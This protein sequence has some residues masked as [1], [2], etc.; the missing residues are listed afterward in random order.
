MA[1]TT[2]ALDIEALGNPTF[3]QAVA[4]ISSSFTL[5][6]GIYFPSVTGEPPT[7]RLLPPPPQTPKLSYSHSHFVRVSL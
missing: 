4:D 3:N 5:L 1:R 7:G 6:V 2:N